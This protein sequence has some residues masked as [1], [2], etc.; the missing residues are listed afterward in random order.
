MS[1][2]DIAPLCERRPDASHWDIWPIRQAVKKA[3][4]KAELDHARREL[5]HILEARASGPE[6][7][8]WESH[9]DRLE[10]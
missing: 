9:W 6:P 2:T 4:E 8:R 10:L 5:I 1:T 7:V 3:E